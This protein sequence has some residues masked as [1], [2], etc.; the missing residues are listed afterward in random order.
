MFFLCDY[1]RLS[2]GTVTGIFVDNGREYIT[3]YIPTPTENEM[4]NMLYQAIN[5]CNSL[6]LTGV[7]DMGQDPSIINLYKTMIED[8]NF[9]LRINTYRLGINEPSLGNASKPTDDKYFLYK[10]RLTVQGVKFFMDG[11]YYI[12]IHCFFS[13]FFLRSF[14]CFVLLSVVIVCFGIVFLVLCLDLYKC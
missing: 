1:Y 14:F 4:K 6:G 2:N 12:H 13:F 3:N 10:D 11:M 8:F 5:E 9:T 7:H